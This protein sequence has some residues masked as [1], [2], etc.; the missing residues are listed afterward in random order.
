MISFEKVKTNS[1]S[2]EEVTR[3]LRSS[4]LKDKFYRE[5]PIVSIKF[6]LWKYYLTISDISI[7]YV[8]IILGFILTC[9]ILSIDNFGYVLQYTG[10]QS[11]NGLHV[12]IFMCLLLI[13]S[14]ASV[15]IL[16]LISLITRTI[17]FCILLIDAIIF[18]I[19]RRNK[20]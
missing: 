3:F 18:N 6:N 1:N 4:F 15:I 13:N 7:F 16:V 17:S 19:I 8:C 20:R 2:K 5:Q 9:S 10:I 11:N 12:T 14:F